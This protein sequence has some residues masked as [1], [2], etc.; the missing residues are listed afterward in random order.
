MSV[1]SLYD[2][3]IAG[4]SGGRRSVHGQPWSQCHAIGQL[5]PAPTSTTP[6][7]IFHRYL[8]TETSPEFRRRAGIA[9]ALLVGGKLLNIQ[10]PFFFKYTGGQGVR[11]CPSLTLGIHGQLQA[12]HNPTCWVSNA[13]GQPRMRESLKHSRLSRSTPSTPQCS[14]RP[15]RRPLRP[16]AGLGGRSPGPGSDLLDPGVRAGAHRRIL[17]QRGQE[18]R[19]CVGEICRA[20]N[21]EGIP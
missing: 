5:L 2:P 21:S 16:H 17:L 10:V 3:L 14:G 15:E 7:H 12:W 18:C 20:G 6:L 8:N 9:L 11:T 1:A 13:A 19:L 4:E